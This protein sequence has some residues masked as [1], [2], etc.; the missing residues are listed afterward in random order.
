M[1]QYLFLFP[2]IEGIFHH[3]YL[4]ITMTIFI[5]FSLTFLMLWFY[6]FYKKSQQ[7]QFCLFWIPYCVIPSK[8]GEP[9][10]PK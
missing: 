2:F 10:D 7:P 5:S 1:K 8:R 9:R 6:S 3:D 4:A